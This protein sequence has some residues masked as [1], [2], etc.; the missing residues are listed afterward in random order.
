[1]LADITPQVVQEGY[2]EQQFNYY[3]QLTPRAENCPLMQNKQ[4]P[5][6]HQYSQPLRSHKIGK[7]PKPK[8]DEG[9]KMEQEKPPLSLAGL[10][11]EMKFIV[12][13]YLSVEEVI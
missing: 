9:L 3:D 13:A 8:F 10:P 12:M 1:M 6:S 4:S 5:L 2:F 11:K 7:L